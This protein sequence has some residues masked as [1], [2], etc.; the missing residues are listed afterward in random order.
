MKSWKTYLLAASVAV[1]SAAFPFF[2]ANAQVN[3]PV[4]YQN[5]TSTA[6]DLVIWGTKQQLKD[7]AGANISTTGNLSVGGTLGVT[8]ATTL[9]GGANAQLNTHGT[10]PA[11][12]SGSSNC[13]TAASVAGNDNAFVITVGYS[14]NGG[15]CPVTFHATWANAPACVS[16]NQTSAARPAYAIT[17]TTTTLAVN[18]SSTFT[19]G[20]LIS[21]ICLGYK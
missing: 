6:G 2:P 19:A 3:Y 12:T 9:T 16:Q 14:T 11:V 18:A 8:G 17:P 13:G 21:V 10:A 7:G 4:T 20:D 1:L 15:T 5:G